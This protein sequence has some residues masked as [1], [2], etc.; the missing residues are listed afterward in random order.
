MTIGPNYIAFEAE[1]TKSP[2]GKWE[3]V[4]PGDSRYLDKKL[5]PPIGETHLEFTGNNPSVGEPNSPLEY[6]FIC[7]KT[8]TYR[9]GA[10]LYQRLMGQPE[11]KCNDVYV[12]MAGDFT[13]ANN[14]PTY[15]LKQNL[16]FFGRGVDKWGALYS[17]ES[18]NFGQHPAIYNL[19]EGELY[20]LTVSG[21]SLIHI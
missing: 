6:K 1:A 9:L 18:H 4:K 10:R 13:T 8:G 19:K 2:L 14:I 3:I 7:P 12:R 16:K 20:T 21:L 15:E 17:L 5:V 11:D